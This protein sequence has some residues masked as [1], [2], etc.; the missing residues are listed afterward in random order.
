MLH[1]PWWIL[2]LAFYQPLQMSIKISRKDTA[3]MI[4]SSFR[5]RAKLLLI[6][7]F[8]C[9]QSL[10]R[11]VSIVNSMV[12]SAIWKRLSKKTIKL[13]E[14]EG[15]VLFEVFEKLTSACFFPNCNFSRKSIIRQTM[16]LKLTLLQKKKHIKKNGN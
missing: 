7:T 16:C 12:S 2:N 5:H 9:V 11:T 15:W 14:S 4:L 6:L 13:H 1:G 3:F 8:S 10:I